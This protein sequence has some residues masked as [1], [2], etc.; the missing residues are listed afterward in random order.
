MT[1]FVATSDDTLRNPPAPLVSPITNASSDDDDPNGIAAA[2]QNM[3][4]TPQLWINLIP[5]N[6]LPFPPNGIKFDNHSWANI[7]PVDATGAPLM[8]PGD[9]IEQIIVDPSN[10]NTIYVYTA[11]G[12]VLQGNF[13]FEFQVDPHSGEIIGYAPDG[14]ELYN[15]DGTMAGPSA[16]IDSAVSVWQNITG[17]LPSGVLPVAVPQ[18]LALDSQVVTDPTDDVLYAGTP[19]SGVWKLTN[20]S[21]DFSTT[22]PV[23]TEVGLDTSGN[24]TIPIASV[25]ALSL[26]TTT[27]I[28]GAATYGRGT[29]EIQVRGLISGHIFT[30]TNGNGMFDTGEPGVA[31]VT[32]EVLDEA[33]AGAVVAATTTDANGFYQFRS[34]TAGDYEVVALTGTGLIETTAEPTDLATFTE[35]ST[36]T[37]DIGFFAPGTI[38]GVKFLD[39]NDDQIQDNGEP[40]LPGFT[41]YID[42]NN[43]GVLDPGE[44]STVTAADGPTPSPTS[45]HP[46]SAESRTR[47]ADRS[48]CAR[49]SNRIMLP[50]F[51]P[52]A[53][54]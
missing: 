16:P 38:S 6:D 5:T 52:P 36:D 22:P 17:N 50:P 25:T 2:V 41:I 47:K 51:P 46:S 15:P 42:L 8:Q 10:N 43:N 26:N 21:A 34:L 53:R 54:P 24:P 18:P 7:T 37:V 49:S 9:T 40:G 44:P 4:P 12:L 19:A 13:A 29:F 1:L 28:L 14:I 39:T 33:N 45:G 27:G 11:S 20:P 35:K 32:V 31:G 3:V 30:D 48:I 23:W